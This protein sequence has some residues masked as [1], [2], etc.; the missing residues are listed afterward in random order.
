MKGMTAQGKATQ[1]GFTLIELMISI[2]IMGILFAVLF[3]SFRDSNER[4]SVNAKRKE[5]R[6]A[7]S[8]ARN[9]ATDRRV[10]VT[11]CSSSNQTSCDGTAW[12]NGWIVWA[13]M[14]G[15][16][17]LDSGEIL[18]VRQAF[19]DPTTMTGTTVYFDK[20]GASVTSTGTAAADAEFKLCPK[21]ARAS[22]AHGIVVMASGVVRY[23]R[24]S[25]GDGIDEDKSGAAYT[26]P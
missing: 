4:G 25:N 16:G 2:V 23:S 19:N 5:I 1:R 9:I 20:S 15:N 3:P 12:K 13:D 18:S 26:C 14:N 21:S 8:Q 6:A 11:V 24:D 10:T 7:M 22:Y 17:T